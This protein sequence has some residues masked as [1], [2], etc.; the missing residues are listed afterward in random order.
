MHHK[1]L[2]HKYFIWAKFKSLFTSQLIHSSRP[3]TSS[4]G[5]SPLVSSV[6]VFSPRRLRSSR[7]GASSCG[8]IWKCQSQTWV[9]RVLLGVP[10]KRTD[11]RSLPSAR[12]APA[13]AARLVCS[14]DSE[15]WRLGTCTIFNNNGSKNRNNLIWQC[16]R[17]IS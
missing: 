12:A 13:A 7:R 1:Y 10:G 17:Q 15:N 16:G 11:W 6:A 14:C 4:L 2:K 3:S 8:W 5:Q 9:F